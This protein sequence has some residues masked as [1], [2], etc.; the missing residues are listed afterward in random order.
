MAPSA[1]LLDV[2]VEILG[3]A[4]F[5]LLFTHPEALVYNTKVSKLLKMP[6]FEQKKKNP[7][8]ETMRIL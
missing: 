4:H 8:W 6:A 7:L 1:I 3:S 2:P 5:H